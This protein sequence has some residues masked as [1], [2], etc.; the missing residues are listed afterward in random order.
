MDNYYGHKSASP[1]VNGF[2]HTKSGSTGNVT[3]DLLRDMKEKDAEMEAMKKREAWMKAAL[4]KATRSGFVYADGESLG[5]DAD[6]ED[7]DSRRVA[8]MVI[9]LKHVKA[10]IQVGVVD[11]QWCVMKRCLMDGFRLLW[12]SRRSRLPSGCPS[13]RRC[14]QAPC[15]RL[16]S[17]AP[18]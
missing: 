12:S 15:R 8:E 4:A 3:A 9:T 5:N 6:D 7:I 14:A 11:M 10:Q 1:S 16:R 13:S 18:S 17:T 2:A